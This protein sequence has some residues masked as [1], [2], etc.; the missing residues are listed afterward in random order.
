MRTVLCALL[1]LTLAACAADNTAEP[2]P[3]IDMHLHPTPWTRY[4]GMRDTS[5]FTRA[6]RATAD[7]M[8]HFNIVLSLGSGP[9]DVMEHWHRLAP[10]RVMVGVLFPC[11]GPLAPNGGRQ[12]FASGDSLPALDWLRSEIEAGRIGFRGE[13]TTQYVGLPPAHPIMEPYYALA[14]E[15]DVPVA[16]HMGNG[17]AG[18]PYEDGPCGP[19]PC[20]RNYRAAYSNA[21]LLEDVLARHPRLR[22]WVMHSGWPLLEEMIQMLYMYPQVYTDIAILGRSGVMPRPAFHDYVC[23]LVRNGFGNRIMHGTD[24]NPAGYREAIEAL[25]SAPCLSAEQKRD[26]LYNNAARFLRLEGPR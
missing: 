7:T 26:I 6:W 1:S 18:A 2:A 13:I 25:E 3:I 19:D 14:E 12:C 21:L 24:A 22:V 20:A 16:I 17:P 11:D 8:D 15:L 23:S 4:D 9:M 10:T 5:D